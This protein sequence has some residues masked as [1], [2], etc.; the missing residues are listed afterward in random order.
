L[1][2]VISV[3]DSWSSVGLRLIFLL[4][5]EFGMLDVRSFSA[6]V[7]LL[8]AG[9]KLLLTV[10]NKED[11]FIS[12]RCLDVIC[13]LLDIIV[14]EFIEEVDDESA[15]N[16]I[17]LNPRLFNLIVLSFSYSFSF[18][19]VIPVELLGLNDIEA[20]EIILAS[21]LLSILIPG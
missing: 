20:E 12:W 13:Q 19:R 3:S 15:W 17:D 8:M 21:N 1:G 2:W 9:S 6:D 7:A 5:L 16:L 4:S 10:P 11:V 14:S 18:V